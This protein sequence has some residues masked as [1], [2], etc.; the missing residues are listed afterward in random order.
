M[1]GE[2]ND[3]QYNNTNIT[4]TN[5]TNNIATSDEL[6]ATLLYQDSMGTNYSRKKRVAKAV[7]ATG[8]AIL[9]TAA[10][11]RAGTAITNAYVLNPPK[12][13]TETF[14]VEEGTFTYSFNLNNEGKYQ[15]TIKIAVND[16]VRYSEDCT[17]PGA[18]EGSFSDFETGERGLFYIEFTNGVDYIKKIRQVRF[19]TKGVSL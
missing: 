16:V 8:I 5:K 4:F 7:G 2:F 18:Y 6:S 1:T 10:S 19:T 15:T 3:F 17:A 13:D 11:V 14:K 9:L 12:T